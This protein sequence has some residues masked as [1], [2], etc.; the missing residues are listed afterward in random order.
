MQTPLLAARTLAAC[1]VIGVVG[2]GDPAPSKPK[3]IPS[4]PPILPGPSD[5]TETPL[6]PGPARPHAPPR[7]RIGNL[8]G[9]RLHSTIVFEAYPDLPH[10]LDVSFAFP[11]RARS[12]LSPADAR[13]AQRA[14]TYRYGEGLWRISPGEKASHEMDPTQ[15]SNAILELELRRALFLW[16]AG[17]EWTDLPEGGQRTEIEGGGY[18]L[19]QFSPSD[20]GHP[21]SLSAFSTDNTPRESLRNIQW[22]QVEGRDRPTHLEV[23]LGESLIWYEEV[24]EVDV[25]SRFLDDWYIPPDRRTDIDTR[26]VRTC[27]PFK[28]KAM[29]YVRHALQGTPDLR[30]ALDQGQSL[31]RQQTHHWQKLGLELTA[32]VHIELTE[33]GHPTAILLVAAGGAPSRIAELDPDASWAH[34][35]ASPALSCFLP[36][37]T[38]GGADLLAL[39]KAAGADPALL[40]MRVQPL[41]T[42][43]RRA[44]LVWVKK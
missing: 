2:C 12:L 11:D 16:P 30:T 37:P 9:I 15:T 4:P 31:F 17:F 10:E 23:Y 21:H 20:P 28:L 33:N 39:R 5:P 36:S 6:R 3:G 24:Q 7:E 8:Q 14:L 13:I 22:A 27:R 35:P 25:S 40:F 1:C 18:L 42:E 29:D 32:S 38:P 34:Q 44:E 43:P 41:G 26:A 19:A